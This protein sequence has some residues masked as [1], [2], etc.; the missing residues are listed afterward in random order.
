MRPLQRLRLKVNNAPPAAAA[1]APA[2]S[3]F[4]RA[5]KYAAKVDPSW[6]P[7]GHAKGSAD[8]MNNYSL[9]EDE[10]DLSKQ[11]RLEFAVYC[12]LEDVQKIRGYVRESWKQ[13]KYGGADLVTA[14]NGELPTYPP[15][16][17]NGSEPF[18]D[19]M[20]ACVVMQ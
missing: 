20:C 9:R 6:L 12:F 4:V 16:Y 10:N 15:T 3:R 2:C 5:N 11:A 13:L 19:N 7:S 8:D 18:A 1:A 14:A 17:R